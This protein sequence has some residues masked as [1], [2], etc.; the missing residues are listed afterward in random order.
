[1]IHSQSTTDSTSRLITVA[2]WMSG[3]LVS[4]AAMAVAVREASDTMQSFEILFF[5]SLI[6][7][8]IVLILVLRRGPGSV[9]TRRPGLQIFRNLVHFGGQFG[10]VYGIALLPL[11][12]VTAIEFTTPV[13]TAILAVLFLGEKMNRG[14]VVAIAL[15]LSGILVILRPGVEIVQLTALI[16]LAS[17]IC[18]A[19]THIL[20]KKLTETDSPLAILFYMTLVQ[21][22]LGL[23]PALSAWVPPTIAD[24]PW[25]VTLGVSAL[26]AHYCLARALRL[27]DATIAVPMDFLRLPLVAFVGF[28][29]YAEE[30]EVALLAGA[31]LIFAGNYY[32]IRRESRVVE[33]ERDAALD[34]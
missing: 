24:A 21:L 16:V 31:V 17:A 12:E 22:P 7:L 14:R 20:T 23:V 18:Y 1:M 32:N 6:G 25:L 15:G 26:T 10:W 2:L 30:F 8:V 11:A 29:L 3:A 9:R 34:R 28:L 27:A 13:W 5:R 33:P 19:S 4:F